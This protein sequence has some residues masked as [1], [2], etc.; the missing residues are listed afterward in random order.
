[1]MYFDFYLLMFISTQTNRFHFYCVL[2]E[3][4]EEKK[5]KKIVFCIIKW[6]K[7]KK[8]VGWIYFMINYRVSY[9]ESIL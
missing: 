1:M 2:F 8:F 4:K 5:M 9:V 3:M 7:K 6:K